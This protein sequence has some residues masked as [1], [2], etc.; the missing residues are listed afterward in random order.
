MYV[1]TLSTTCVSRTLPL[2]SLIFSDGAGPTQRL[3]ADRPE[4]NLPLIG[5][6]HFSRGPPT[7]TNNARSLNFAGPFNIRQMRDHVYIT[8]TRLWKLPVRPISF[9]YRPSI[10]P[11]S[12][13]GFSY[14]LC[15]THTFLSSSLSYHGEHAS[16]VHY[17][18]P[19]K[20]PR[21]L[22]IPSNQSRIH[23]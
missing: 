7:C 10:E 12:N 23:P 20:S 22:V 19:P 13:F 8:L 6:T 14:Y 15:F 1:H 2:T 4:R 16:H 5:T 3:G 17:S 18:Q 21:S 9:L 11:G